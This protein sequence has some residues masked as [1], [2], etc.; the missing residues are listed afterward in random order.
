MQ[1]AALILAV[2]GLLV[3]VYAVTVAR[4]QYDDARSAWLQSDFSEDD[5][6]FVS[7]RRDG[8]RSL[9]QMLTVIS[10]LAGLAGLVMGFVARRREVSTP[11]ILATV[12]GFAG[13]ICA[14]IAG[15]SNGLF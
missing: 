15:T 2:I 13:L 5:Y 3:G 8:A 12:F 6:D 1:L 14:V 9:L 10:G 7:D 4:P 11:A